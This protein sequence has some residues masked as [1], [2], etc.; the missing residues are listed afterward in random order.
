MVVLI[1]VVEIVI[2]VVHSG[3]EWSLEGGGDRMIRISLFEELSS[4]AFCPNIQKRLV[5]YVMQ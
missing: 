5:A 4:V 2:V 1:V 3:L